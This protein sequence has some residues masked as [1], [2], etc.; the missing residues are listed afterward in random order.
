[1]P[2]ETSCTVY[3]DTPTPL[4]EIVEQ[5][6]AHVV[7]SAQRAAIDSATLDIYVDE[8]DEHDPARASD[9]DEGFL[10]FPFLVDVEAQPGV[11]P[12]AYRAALNRLLQA[13]ARPGV[14]FVTAADDEPSLWNGGRWDGTSSSTPGPG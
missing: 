1:M 9:L 6:S 2:S 3:L 13:L 4:S 10:F 8:N 12:S 5:I 7:G 14:R 11:A